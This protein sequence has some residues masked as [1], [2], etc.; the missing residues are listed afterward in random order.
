MKFL[1]GLFSSL[2]ILLASSFAVAD[3]SPKKMMRNMKAYS[4]LGATGKLGPF[5][6]NVSQFGTPPKQ[7]KTSVENQ[8]FNKI[9]GDKFNIAAIVMTGDE[10][11]YERYNTKRKI[12]SNTPLMGMSMSKT[13]ASAAIGVLLCDGTIKSIDDVAGAYSPTL[14]ASPYANVS[15]KNILQMNSGVSPIGRDDEK[16]FNQKSRGLTDKFSGKASVRGA[17]EFYQ[18][19][20]RQQN[21]TMNYHSTD[22]LALSVLIEEAS[23]RSLAHIFHDKLYIKFGQSGYMYWTA[24]KDGTT[25]SFSDLTMTGRDWAHFGKF[26]MAEKKSKSCLGSFFNDGVANSVATGKKNGSRYGYQSWVYDVNGKAAMVLQGHGG[27]FVVLDETT[28][29]VLLTI[30]MNENYKAG[31]LFNNIHKFAEKLN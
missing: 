31:N 12:N 25:V 3:H 18:K 6:V 9:F 10:I 30:S 13:G 23:D 21:S 14:K 8:K 1:F 2:T 19:A 24:D 28:D 4:Q 29:T 27:Q 5:D 15:I 17:L 20:A 7:K 11:V 16:R 22:T 26:I